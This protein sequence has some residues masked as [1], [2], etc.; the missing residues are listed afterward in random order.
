[1][2]RRSRRAT[3][4]RWVGGIGFVFTL[5]L[6]MG[7][8]ALLG[9]SLYVYDSYVKQFTTPEEELVNQS[10]AGARV[11]DRNG[12]LLYEF[13][14]ERNGLRRPISLHDMSKYLL[15]ATIATEDADFFENSGVNVRGL[16]RATW[17]NVS[18]L[19]SDSSA[20]EGSGGS[21]ITQQLAKNLYIP[22]EDRADRSVSRK[23]RETVFALEL[24]RRYEKDQVLEWYLNQISYGGIYY[25]AEAA[26][27]GYFGKSASEL[28]LA[29]A[30]LLAG[31]PQSP[32]LLEP[33]GN[34]EAAKFRR[35]QVLDL[36]QRRGSI[37]IGE[38]EWL[39]IS[40]E[41]IQAALQEEVAVRPSHFEV[42]AAHFVFSQIKPQ[43]DAM[44][45]PEAIFRDG[46]TITTS[47]DLEL[48][49]QSEVILERWISEFERTSNSRNGA[50]M[51]MDPRTGEIWVYIGS[52]D[53]FRED[54]EGHNDN[55]MSLNSPGS[56][57]KPFVYATTFLDLG[58][59]PGTVIRDEPVNFRESDGTVFSPRNPN[60]SYN[61]A[62]SVRDALGNSL[63]I[64]AFKAAQAVGVPKIVQNAKN[65]GFSTLTGHYG[66]S[67]AIGG[68]DLTAMDLTAGYS[69]FA[70]GG[71][72]R[73]YRPNPETPDVIEPAAILKVEDQ[74]GQ[75]LFDIQ[76]HRAERQVIDPERAYMINSIL[77]D[78]R[79]QCITFGCGGLQLPGKQVAVKT[80][81]SEPFDPK[82][83]NAG[84]IGD[85][86]AF[87]YSPDAVVGVWAGNA[88]NA[89]IVNIFS[90]SISYRAMRDI[91]IAVYR[92]Y[93]W[94]TFPQ[95]EGLTTGSSCSTVQT[96]AG[97]RND[98]VL[99]PELRDP[100][101]ATSSAP[102]AS[103][104]P[105]GPT[106]TPL[107]S[108][109]P[110]S[111]PP[112]PNQ[113]SSNQ[114]P[115]NQGVA[116]QD[117]SGSTG[118]SGGGGRPQAVITSPSGS[119]SGAVTIMGTASGPY[120]LAVQQAGSG[121]WQGMGSWSRPVAGGA[122]GTFVTSGLQ[123]GTYTIRL[124]VQ[125]P[126]GGTSTDTVTVTVN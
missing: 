99:K 69:V 125:D 37:R 13:V 33:I 123:P 93:P 34:P 68:V 50:A 44:F 15:A 20:F 30:A 56:S 108:Q 90:T 102:A 18:P 126:N 112:P 54:L 4:L 79:A 65:F 115:S 29:E 47:L 8:A 2:K 82:G 71:I 53:Y 70:S 87:G 95:P 73:G 116:S 113:G 63:N 117:A 85:T 48:Q 19:A 89:P 21:S 36:I 25:G 9:G 100:R 24:T 51:V 5:F 124:T 120:S 6:A 121:N 114:V 101:F 23:I 7:V 59:S 88:N 83:P 60:G 1:L 75:V 66:P 119:V 97:C 41:E 52:R 42:N 22:F 55:L 96:G 104:T 110:G 14:D 80:G 72:A 122:L 3:L 107:P 10:Y 105:A 46:L 31:I 76:Q 74:H 109:L 17:E 84:K 81:T 26:S 27:Q 32:A 62:V 103:P 61:G 16:A 12:A 67:I 28:T 92:D 39:T 40:Q 11:Y 43:I 77:S 111:Q 45:G 57:F 106:P 35:D 64:P 49:R 91:L 118:G 94:A 38:N 58:W 78:P 86:W 98:L